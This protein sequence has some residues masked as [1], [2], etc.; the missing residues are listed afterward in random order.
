MI[1]DYDTVL[2]IR[3]LLPH[4]NLTVAV[5]QHWYLH[6]VGAPN[7]VVYESFVEDDFHSED[8]ARKSEICI[9]KNLVRILVIL[10]PMCP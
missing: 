1:E 9:P 4:V 3:E 7:L 2:A 6:I 10:T 5:S 8:P